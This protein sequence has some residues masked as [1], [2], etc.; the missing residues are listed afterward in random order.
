MEESKPRLK[1]IHIDEPKHTAQTSLGK[2]NAVLRYR[3]DIVLF[4]YPMRGKTPET[5]FNRYSPIKKPRRKLV[6]WKDSFRKKELLK[7]HPWL[8][9]DIKVLESIE[10]LWKEDHQVMLYSIDAPSELTQ[11]MIWAGKDRDVWPCWVT[12]FTR[13]QYMIRNLGYVEQKHQLEK[14]C[15]VLVLVADWHWENIKFLKT[16]P[17]EEKVWDRYFG[18]FKKLTPGNIEDRIKDKN[19]ILFKYWRKTSLW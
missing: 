15:K 13:E 10:A 1:L 19:K 9:G 4:E 7:I 11:Q 5:V 17:S 3:P 18:Q 14:N 12:N 8:R 16:H 2:A 6:G